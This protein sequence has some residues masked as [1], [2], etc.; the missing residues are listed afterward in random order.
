M[1]KAIE[2]VAQALCVSMDA[3][4]DAQNY[5]ET[6]SG[7]TPKEM[8]EGFCH[9]AQAALSAYHAHLKAEGM[10]IVPVE[11]NYILE[12]VS[13]SLIWRV[14]ILFAFIA[15]AGSV[16]VSRPDILANNEFLR[17]FM[18]PDMMAVLVVI[19]TITFASVANIHLSISRMVSGAANK[20]AASRAAEGVRTQINSNAWVIFWAFLVAI[21]ALFLH[22]QFPK[23]AMVR[24]FATA[25]CLTVL[26][27]NGLVMHDLYRTI[28]IL[29]SNDPFAPEPDNGEDYTS[30]S[31]PTG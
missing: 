19:L 2:I 26:L 22:G 27:L 16:S 31:P 20:A 29:V 11:G 5:Q 7:E 24:S 14:G 8:R 10:V 18:G 15:I 6:P 28:F 12:K 13:R 21:I 3:R 17:A 30:E 4:W 1:D 23:E 9:Q 25:A